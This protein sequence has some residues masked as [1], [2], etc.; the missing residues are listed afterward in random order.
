MANEVPQDDAAFAKKADADTKADAKGDAVI[1]QAAQ[2][3]ADPTRK[4]TPAEQ[5]AIDDKTKPN[6]PIPPDGAVNA[7]GSGY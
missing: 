7:M 2:D 1:E 4:L 6:S 3:A 5:K